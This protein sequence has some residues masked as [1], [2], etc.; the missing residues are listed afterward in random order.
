ML[1]SLLSGLY[2]IVPLEGFCGSVLLVVVT[3]LPP[4]GKPPGVEPSLRRSSPVSTLKKIFP[5]PP[6]NDSMS[7]LTK[8]AF[9]LRKNAT[10]N[11][12]I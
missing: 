2:Q 7:F 6:I 11:S 9:I 12:L 5:C 8:P 10:L 3:E 1:N 4:M